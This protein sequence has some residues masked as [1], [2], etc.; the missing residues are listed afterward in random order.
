MI[1]N[2]KERMEDRLSHWYKHGNSGP[3]NDQ[4]NRRRYIA[5]LVNKTSMFAYAKKHNIPLPHRYAEVS[6]VGD[7]DFK[8]FPER[9]VVKPNNSADSDCVMLFSDGKEIFSG[10]SVLATEMSAFIEKAFAAGRFLNTH[11]KILVEEFIQDYDKR[12]LIP[13]DF[14]VYVAGGRAHF[15]QVIDRNGPKAAWNHSFYD[16][17]WTDIHDNMQETYRQGPKIERPARLHELVSLS[18]KIAQD[19]GCFMRLDFFISADRVVFGE[20]TSYPFAGMRYTPEGDRQL[21][22][23]MNRF[24]DPF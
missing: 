8:S 1:M 14:K 10:E 2:F 21:C 12:F 20:F 18:E 6:N 24:P 22:Y 13:R 23:L 3:E 11:T 7:L 17:E 5:G 4:T 19:I 9:V 16:R 15:I